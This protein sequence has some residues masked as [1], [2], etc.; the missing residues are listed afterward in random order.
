MIVQYGFHSTQVQRI[1]SGI[2]LSLKTLLLV[3]QSFQIPVERLVA[4]IGPDAA[5]TPKKG[6][7]PL[8]NMAKI[9]EKSSASGHRELI[10]L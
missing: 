2:G 7:P 6:V 5:I 4:E 10:N 3:A 9:G 1:E 8:K